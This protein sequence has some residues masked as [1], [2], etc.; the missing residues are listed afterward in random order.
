MDSLGYVLCKLMAGHRITGKQDFVEESEMCLVA[1]QMFRR[2]GQIGQEGPRV[3]RIRI[4]RIYQPTRICARHQNFVDP[5]SAMLGVGEISGTQKD[6]L[7]S[8]VAVALLDLFSN[9]A[10]RFWRRRRVFRGQASP[11]WAGK[12]GNWKTCWDSSCFIENPKGW[13]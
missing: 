13:T 11:R 1:G 4:T 12:F 5:P 3:H 10:R 9:V 6:R 8:A 7:H 2:P